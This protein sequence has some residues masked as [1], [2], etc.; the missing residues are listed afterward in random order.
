MVLWRDGEQQ[1]RCF[2]DSCPH[3]CTF[4]IFL[5]VPSLEIVQECD[6]A[7]AY[8]CGDELRLHAQAQGMDL[9]IAFHNI[10]C[11]INVFVCM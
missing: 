9:W 4:C 6:H 5:H 7:H 11:F 2:E 10:G 1:W 3:R 8:H